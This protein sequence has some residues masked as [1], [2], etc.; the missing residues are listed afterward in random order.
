VRQDK[1]RLDKTRQDK[2]RQTKT[3]IDRLGWGQGLG[4]GGVRGVRVRV[5]GRWGEEVRN[6]E[7]EGKIRQDKQ[8]E[9]RQNKTRQDKTRLD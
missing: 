8:D 6:G 1:P 4:E 5:R 2:T 3:G 7:G 9:T